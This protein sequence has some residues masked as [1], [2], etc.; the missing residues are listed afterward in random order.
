LTSKNILITGAGGFIGSNICK[1]LLESK[2]SVTTLCKNNIKEYQDFKK[3]TGDISNKKTFS[4]IKSNFDVVLHL[5]SYLDVKKSFTNLNETFQTNIRG[6]FNLLEHFSKFQQKP[7]FVF[8]SSSVVYGT[9]K[10]ISIA[11][12]DA[13]NP[14]TPYATSKLAAENLFIGFSNSFNIPV[15]IL[16]PFSVFGFGAPTHQRIPIV[17]KQIQ[18]KHKVVVDNPNEVRDLIFVDDVVEASLSVMDHPPKL[19]EIYNLGSGKKISMYKLVKKITELYPFKIK[20]TK[21]KITNLNSKKSVANISKIQQQFNW[22]P[23]T[24]LEQ[25]LRK[26]IEKSY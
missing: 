2:H 15:S 3:I 8:F 17:L 24:S 18:Q 11:E 4:K 20:I 6:T 23:K 21:G 25:G 1:K 5:A 12:T 19:F 10:N 14:T 13:V 22:K 16:R 7:H 26:T 9:T